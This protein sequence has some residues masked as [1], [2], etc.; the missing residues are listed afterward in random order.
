MNSE[1]DI[2]EE[3]IE[4]LIQKKKAKALKEDS[5][6]R[7]QYKNNNRDYKMKDINGNFGIKFTKHNY[8][9]DNINDLNDEILSDEIESNSI[10]SVEE[11]NISKHEKKINPIKKTNSNEAQNTRK[12]EFSKSDK[13]KSDLKIENSII[14]NREIKENRG[15]I[16]NFNF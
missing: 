1:S 6:K 2:S 3:M 8:K 14:L 13:K 11:I 12:L 16:Y 4:T 5:S 10:E 9:K 15:I 7:F